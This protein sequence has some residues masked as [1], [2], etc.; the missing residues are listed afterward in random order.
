MPS[1]VRSG[2][3]L[4]RR[5]GVLPRVLCCLQ[6]AGAGPPDLTLLSCRHYLPA[7]LP[8]GEVQCCLCTMRRM[9]GWVAKDCHRRPPVSSKKGRHGAALRVFNGRVGGAGSA[10]AASLAGAALSGAPRP[11]PTC[12]CC[13]LLSCVMAAL[14]V[15]AGAWNQGSFIRRLDLPWSS[16]HLRPGVQQQ[17]PGRQAHEGL[18][19][20]G[21]QRP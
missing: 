18:H 11:P 9:A 8:P 14:A 19:P 16:P 21:Q 10:S 15:V 6:P 20:R 12:R 7:H 3:P 13:C 4:L 5:A 2:E 17:Q 1:A